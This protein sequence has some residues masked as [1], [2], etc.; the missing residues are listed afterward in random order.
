MLSLCILLTDKFRQQSRTGL[1][2]GIPFG[3][4]FGTGV[5]D[6]YD[7]VWVYCLV[8]YQIRTLYPVQ[9]YKTQR[10]YSSSPL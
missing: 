7:S 2:R 5:L 8:D 3:Y 6:E 9:K 10:F 1:S 4:G